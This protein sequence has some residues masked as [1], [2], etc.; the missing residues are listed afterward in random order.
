AS[1]LI[2]A[3]T[4]PSRDDVVTSLDRLAELPPGMTLSNPAVAEQLRKQQ[5]EWFDS[6]APTALFEERFSDLTDDEGAA[7]LA[8]LE[9]FRDQQGASFP[10]GELDAA[11]E[12]HWARYRR[13]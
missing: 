9:A 8:F 2:S 6:G 12:R 1:E 7:I 13:G 5:L 3:L 11:I 4:E 10:F